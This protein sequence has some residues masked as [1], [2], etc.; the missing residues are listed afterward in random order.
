MLIAWSAVRTI[1][2]YAT[3]A[4]SCFVAIIVELMLLNQMFNLY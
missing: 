1:T 3:P 4:V 2:M